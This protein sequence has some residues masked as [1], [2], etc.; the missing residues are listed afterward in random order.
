MDG[1]VHNCV[2]INMAA[3]VVTTVTQAAF[4]SAKLHL[5]RPFLDVHSRL[6]DSFR[7]RWVGMTGAGNIL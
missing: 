5:H 7:N 1:K 4:L 6:S 2:Y 3:P